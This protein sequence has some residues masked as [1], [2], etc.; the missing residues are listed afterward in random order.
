M[1]T[2]LMPGNAP[3]ASECSRA[4]IPCRA[5]H[6]PDRDRVPDVVTSKFDGIFDGTRRG[7]K[8]ET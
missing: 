1:V 6:A 3:D 4:V 5:R 8:A 7:W 2:S